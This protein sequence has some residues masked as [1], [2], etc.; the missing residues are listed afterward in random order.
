MLALAVALTVFTALDSLERAG[1]ICSDDAVRTFYERRG[2]ASAWDEVNAAAL[3]R[4]V[5]RAGEEALDPESYPLPSHDRPADERDVLMTDAFLTYA[6]HL[7]R[8]RLN[9]EFD[10]C[11]PPRE[12]DL[13]A[14]LASAL[15][16]RTVEEML[17]RLVPRH[18]AY[19]KLRDA[20]Q[21]YRAMA[22]WKA[23]P[24]GPTMRVGDHGPRVAQ[25]RERLGLG[26]AG[27][28][29]DGAFD[30]ALHEAVREFQ[31]RHGLVEDGI[32]GPKTFAELNVSRAERLRQ[33][34]LNL[35][36]W[37]WMPDDLG[38]TYLLVNIA[39]F[40]VTV[41]ESDAP[42]LRMR[43]V[44]GK[45]LT[46]TPF[47]TARVEGVTVNPPWNVPDSIARGEL[48]PKQRRDRSYFAREH[49]RVLPGGRLR[50]DPGPWCA[51][52]RIKLEMPNRHNVYLHDTPARSLFA[53]DIRAFSHGC[54]RMEKPVAM[55]SALTGRTI[56]EIEQ[57][58]AEE[59]QLT[60]PLERPLPV[61]VLYWTAFVGDDGAV[62]FRRDVYGQ[63]AAMV[64]AAAAAAAQR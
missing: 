17:Q 11:S 54:I 64:A 18:E 60:I 58:I 59:R 6:T 10:W 9:P 14:L 12:L 47:F 34:G 55:A 16:D 35:E 29:S 28:G 40:D 53:T 13:A 8:G 4:A 49:I 33:L 26:P 2:G 43:I 1:S 5:A 30:A 39:A 48:W 57:L 52:G 31:R 44:A 3:V 63:D 37:R 38:E 51:L 23:I 62:E 42:R 19:R 20:W 15:A 22:D 45:D 24:P 32:V 7:L 46:R 21:V 36:R 25:L 41:I 61:Y 50:Q 27:A 56:A